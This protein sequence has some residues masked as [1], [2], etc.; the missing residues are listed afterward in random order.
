MVVDSCVS[1]ATF[2]FFFFDEEE[3]RTDTRPLL[4]EGDVVVPVSNRLK[5]LR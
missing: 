5:P 1:S 3:I 2:L 4:G